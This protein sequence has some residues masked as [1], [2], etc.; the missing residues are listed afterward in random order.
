[1]CPL[2][3]FFRAHFKMEFRD[4]AS[5]QQAGL[6]SAPPTPTPPPSRVQGASDAPAA[7][8]S[9]AC[10]PPRKRLQTSKSSDAVEESPCP[11]CATAAAA[12]VVAAAAARAP[13]S[14]TAA[15]PA[16]G[17]KPT[18]VEREVREPTRAER[19]ARSYARL[20][21][22]RARAERLLAALPG[23]RRRHFELLHGAPPRDDAGRLGF[24]LANVAPV[25]ER[26][27]YTLLAECGVCARAERVADWLD[28]DLVD[29]GG[30]LYARAEAMV[31]TV[32][33]STGRSAD[34]CAGVAGPPAGLPAGCSVM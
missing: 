28:A 32:A 22:H 3:D 10:A 12:A 4:F 31:S 16:T 18:A 21:A 1:M 6:A 7:M 26:T 19:R 8:S 29:A 17:V 23:D 13:T 34:D 30:G 25:P 2:E 24:W 9:S 20:A 14:T 33:N 15:A 11:P 5:P 27:R